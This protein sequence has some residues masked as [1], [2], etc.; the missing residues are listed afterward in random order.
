MIRIAE[1][2]TIDLPGSKIILQSFFFKNSSI[3]FE[4]FL[5]LFVIIIIIIYT[6]TTP[7][8]NFQIYGLISLL[9]FDYSKHILIWLMTKNLTTDIT[10]KHFK[11]RY[12]D[13]FE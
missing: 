3:F 13:L 4:Y 7:K 11:L 5:N 1:L 6:Y 12:F 9:L 10:L 8:I 2:P